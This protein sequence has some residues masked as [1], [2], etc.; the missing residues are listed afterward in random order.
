L[1]TSGNPRTSSVAVAASPS[2]A[3]LGATVTLTATVS[4]SQN[5]R[6][7]GQVMFIVNGAVVGEGTLSPLGTVTARAAL[8]TSALPHGSHRV[9]AVYL[10]D[11]T[12]RAFHDVDDGGG[13]LGRSQLAERLQ[14]VAFR[15]IGVAKDWWCWI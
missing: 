7:T 14:G 5:Q 13:E 4:G 15:L 11:A 1:R 3:T 9:D 8:S 6:P 10:G 2:P 12:F